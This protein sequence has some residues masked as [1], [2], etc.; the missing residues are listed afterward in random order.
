MNQVGISEIESPHSF[1]VCLRISAA[2]LALQSFS[3]EI[4]RSL[5]VPGSTPATLFV[6]DNFP[7]DEPIAND[8][9]RID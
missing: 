8:L 4:Q 9:R 5:A 2:K 7:T 3:Q 6:L 1:Q